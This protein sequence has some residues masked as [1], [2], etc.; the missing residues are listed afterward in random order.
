MRLSSL[1]LS[2]LCLTATACT[3]DDAAVDPVWGKQ[4]CGHCAML[5]SDH[6]HGAQLVDER[7]ER[8]FFDDLGCMVAW[9]AEHPAFHPQHWVRRADTQDWAPPES[10]GYV[11]A[12]NSPMD[13]GFQAV[14]VGGTADW[15]AVV[16]SVAQQLHADA[17]AGQAQGSARP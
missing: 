16:A 10:S 5:V 15:N 2:V 17:R 8:L 11:H 1:W 7:G 14:S 9:E 4:P 12:P 3:R 6:S 13:F